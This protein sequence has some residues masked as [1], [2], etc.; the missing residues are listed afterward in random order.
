[1][2]EI[3]RKKESLY[4]PKVVEACLNVFLDHGFAW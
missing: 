4:D 2:R 1:L 3:V